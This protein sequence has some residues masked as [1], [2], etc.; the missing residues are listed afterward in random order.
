MQDRPIDAKS[1]LQTFENSLILLSNGRAPGAVVLLL[2]A[3]ESLLKQIPQL[4]ANQKTSVQKV[5][6]DFEE[7]HRNRFIQ[8]SLILKRSKKQFDS[9]MNIP[10]M[11]NKETVPGFRKLRNIYVH[12]GSSPEDDEKAYAYFARIGLPY[13][14]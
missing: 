3:L 14:T 9:W 11:K 1:S 7:L 6:K 4:K 13:F 2:A 10:K 12:K 5:I 8:K